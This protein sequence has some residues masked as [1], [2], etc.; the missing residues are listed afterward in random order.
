VLRWS[1]DFTAT[2][3]QGFAVSDFLAS[4]TDPS[5]CGI[6]TRVSSTCTFA[7]DARHTSLFTNVVL[8]VGTTVAAASGQ[9]V[10]TEAGFDYVGSLAEISAVPEP[11]TGWLLLS[12]MLLLARW[13]SWWRRS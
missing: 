3:G 4:E 2:A 8:D 7:F 5:F 1:L 13:S 11:S 10:R 12:G 9:L 6:D